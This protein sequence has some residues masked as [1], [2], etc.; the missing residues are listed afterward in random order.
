MRMIV[1]FLKI[2][3]TGMVRNCYDRQSTAVR[4]QEASCQRTKLFEPEYMTVTNKK[5]IGNHALASATSKL[6]N[7][8]NRSFFTV[9]THKTQTV[10]WMHKSRKF[11]EKLRP[12]TTYCA[13]VSVS[14]IAVAAASTRRLWYL[15]C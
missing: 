13:A 4:Q 5:L 12:E 1:K 2:V 11:M 7:D 3:Y 15:L 10:D 6:R 9:K 8:I 14:F